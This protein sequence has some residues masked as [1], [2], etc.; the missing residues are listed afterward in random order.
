MFG[1]N[2]KKLVM[3]AFREETGW[4]WGWLGWRLFTVNPFVAFDFELNKILKFTHWR[5]KIIKTF[6]LKVR[7]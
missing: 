2:H 6:N 4:G 7:I 1:K 3:V 5:S